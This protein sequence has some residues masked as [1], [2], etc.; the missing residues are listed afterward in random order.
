LERLWKYILM[1][2]QNVMDFDELFFFF[3]FFFK[4]K[5]F[6]GKPHRRAMDLMTFRSLYENLDFKKM[7]A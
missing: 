3:N 4:K 7:G 1:K 6:I 5:S 2:V